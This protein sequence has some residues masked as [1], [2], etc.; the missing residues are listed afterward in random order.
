MKIVE[1][2]ELVERESRKPKLKVLLGE[3]FSILDTLL[4]EGSLFLEKGQYLLNKDAFTENMLCFLLGGNIRKLDSCHSTNVIAM[5]LLGQGWE[6]IVITDQQTGGKGRQGRTWVSEPGKNLLFSVARELPIPITEVSKIP[7][8]W[9]AQIAKVLDLYVK[10]PNDIID[11][12]DRKVGGILSSVH[13]SSHSSTKVVIGIGL[14]I[15]QE[16][17][18]A[19]VPNA[20]SLKLIKGSNFSRTELLKS[21]LLVLENSWKDDL[22]VWRKRNRTLGRRIQIGERSGI[23]TGLREDGALLLDGHPILM[24]DVELIERGRSS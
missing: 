5:D 16:S 10:W 18:P 17:F 8:L 3:H 21:V 22:S 2:L 24:G 20:S 7:L 14:N 13:S 4:E 19:D 6:G 12:Q 1:I 9:S 23:A 11:S 15:N